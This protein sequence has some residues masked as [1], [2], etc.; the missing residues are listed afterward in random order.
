MPATFDPIRLADEGVR[1]TGVVPARLLRRLAEVN[2]D[3]AAQVHVDLQFER[4]ANGQREMHGRIEVRAAVAC[5]RCLEPLVLD[6]VAEPMLFFA[7]P[8]G[9]GEP[10]GVVLEDTE[11]LPVSEPLVLNEFVEDELLLALPMVPMHAESE[12]RARGYRP[13]AGSAG[14]TDASERTGPFASLGRLKKRNDT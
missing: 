2:L 4:T 3:E 9:T 5:Q 12:C 11:Q 6:L 1:L 10:G 7:R 8:G 14:S 13:P